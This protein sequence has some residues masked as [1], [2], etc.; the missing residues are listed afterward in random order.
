MSKELENKN[1][2]LNAPEE[3][4]A[5]QRASI[6]A[7]ALDSGGMEP[8]AIVGMS[9]RVPGAKTLDQFWSNLRDGVESTTFFSDEELLAA[10]LSQQ[11]IDHPDLVKAFGKLKDA[12]LF[13][14]SFFE[15]TPREAEI[16]DPQHRQMLECSWEALENAGYAPG[17]SDNQRC[18]QI[19]LFGGIG[20]NS[21]LVHHLLDKKELIETLGG[22]QVTLGNDKDF[23]LTR[24]AYKLNLCG[25][26]VSL[27]TACS[28]SLV[29]VSMGCQSLLSNQ[30]DM[31]IAGGCSIHLPQDQGYMFHRGGTLSADGRCRAFDIEADGTLDGNGAAM[32]VLK[33]YNDALEDGD[34]IQGVIRGFAFNNDGAVKVGYTAPSVEG[35]TAVILDAHHAAG[36][37]GSDIGYV[38]THG[39]G[40]DLGDLV[41]ITALKEAFAE[42]GCS[43]SQCGL[44]SVKTNLGHLDTAAGTTS[45]IK[46]VLAL[47]HEKI[48]P[49]LHFNQANPSLELENSP[50]YV[51]ASLR[52]WPQIGSAPRR[53]GVS[54]FGIGGTNAHIVLEQA[55]QQAEADPP[56]SAWQ[57]L[58]LSARTDEALRESEQRLGEYLQL[59]SADF[60]ASESNASK[61]L[62]LADLAFTLQ[63]G[64]K[65]FVKRRVAL[66][67]NITALQTQLDSCQQEINAD[68]NLLPLGAKDCSPEVV[69]LFPGVDTQYP[70]MAKTL[71]QEEALFRES[72]DQCA[73]LLKTHHDIDLHARLFSVA[74]CSSDENKSSESKSSESASFVNDPLPLFVVEYSLARFWLS[75]G[76]KPSAMLGYSLGEYVCACVAGVLSLQDALTLAVQGE[77]LLSLVAEGVAVGVAASESEILPLLPSGVGIAMNSAPRQCVVAGDPVVM[78]GFKKTIQSAGFSS[79][80]VPMTVPFHTA[81]ME[82][83]VVAYREVLTTISF[84]SPQIPYISCVTG[85]WIRPEQACDPEHYLRLAADTIRL[86]DG[87][88]ALWKFVASSDSN[89]LLELGPSQTL[90]SLALLQNDRPTSAQVISCLS[91]PRYAN[92]NTDINT[93]TNAEQPK[94]DSYFI[95]S[96]LAKVWL[97]GVDIDWSARYEEERRLRIPLPTYPFAKQRYWVDKE[98]GQQSGSSKEARYGEKN[99]HGKCHEGEQDDGKLADPSDWFY[100]PQ[101]QESP[102]PCSNLLDQPQLNNCRWLVVA[103]DARFKSGVPSEMFKALQQLEGL[104]L[105]KGVTGNQT[106]RKSDYEFEVDPSSSKAWDD[107]FDLLE[108]PIDHLVFCCDSKGGDNLQKGFYNLIALAQCL[109]KRLFSEKMQITLL[110]DG[111][112]LLPSESPSVPSIAEAAALSAALGPLRVIPQEYPNISCRTIDLLMPKTDWQQQRALSALLLELQCG[113]GDVALRLDH[114]WQQGFQPYALPVLPE[115]IQQE[116]YLPKNACY[117][118]TGGLGN[119]GL[120]LAAVL[121]KRGSAANIVLTTRRYL[122]ERTEW[123]HDA[124]LSEL[125]EAL[126]AIEGTGATVIVETADVSDTGVMTALVKQLK[127]RYGNI[128]GVIHAAGVVGEA[129]FATLSE[130]SEAFCGTQLRAKL[131]GSLALQSALLES[132]VTPDFCILCSS[133][134]PILGGLGFAAYAASNA[135]MDT[136]VDLHNAAHPNRWIGINWEGWG[137]DE[138]PSTA[139][140]STAIGTSVEEVSLTAQEGSDAFERILALVS[141]GNAPNHLV[142]STANLA[143][144]IQKWVA[145]DHAQEERPM[146]ARHARPELLA[147]Y[148]KPEGEVDIK[149]AQLWENLLGIDGL[150]TNDNFF[151]IGGNSLLLTQLLAQIR[152]AFRLDLSLSMLF[153]QPTIFEMSRLI[154]DTCQTFRDDREEG[155]I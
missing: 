93:N 101:W 108:G 112:F 11:E 155:E 72:V 105:F 63:C 39:T 115:C 65:S 2:S 24:V 68:E 95:L 124:A 84:N 131:T 153:D 91:D 96:A 154:E 28:T 66:V 70:G 98:S 22:W 130:S 75:L 55:N 110:A 16:L 144:R 56:K 59:H 25:P 4:D 127:H 47:K 31:V 21:Y 139:M 132:A 147:D 71:Y 99:G 79:V 92:V 148:V 29:A 134:S 125:H 52:D 9:L 3:N 135:S 50:F 37:D 129:S 46:T 26:A 6:N 7:D 119:I 81:C 122:P 64:R 140:P 123:L 149:V 78:E 67:S 62:A 41:E 57:L 54:S 69:F 43:A 12:D 128:T 145:L 150:G 141:T 18:G 20:F 15:L 14:A 152:K 94:S 44:G 106:V 49:S 90:A 116:K 74:K 133:L 117:L 114:R 142:L 86:T 51:N 33:R 83:F 40:T 100:Q 5:D 121:A 53:A 13:D 118:I 126:L 34:T 80:A 113:K 143:A 107:F 82:P 146:Q 48:P 23:A 42:V 8:I 61:P 151:E 58:P 87:F 45:L 32:V 120:T 77:R 103:D 97:A 89:L 38:E 19:G 111:I 30:C 10:G 137:F 36:V 88:T 27:N 102:L 138:M 104:Q 35:Q 109:G 60:C 85:D 73:A 76:I 1:S 17:S 136:I